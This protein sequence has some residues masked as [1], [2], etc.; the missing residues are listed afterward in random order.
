MNSN[1]EGYI[2]QSPALSMPAGLNFAGYDNCHATP[3][4]F[5][6]GCLGESAFPSVTRLVSEL[7]TNDVPQLQ[8]AGKLQLFIMTTTACLVGHYIKL[9]NNVSGSNQIVSLI[10]S[11]AQRAAI[12]DETVPEKNGV[13]TRWHVVLQE[14]SKKILDDFHSCNPL[15][16]SNN[17]SLSDRVVASQV[18]ALSRRVELL[19]ARI[20]NRHEDRTAVELARD[21]SAIQA[22]QV[23]QLKIDN[24]ML[25]RENHRLKSAL[26][27]LAA[28]SPAKGT[29]GDLRSP[30]P[31]EAAS[32]NLAA[33]FNWPLSGSVHQ[34]DD[35]FVNVLGLQANLKETSVVR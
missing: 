14:W 2:A 22:S 17:S 26:A 13:F 21:S 23:H 3:Q 18:Q 9:V 33:E 12:N 24:E 5:S 6:F 20:Q 7:F 4:A 30:L 1:A 32:C 29:A 25:K 27:S 35:S 19:G 8:E 11:A 10:Q 31:T 28:Q 15:E 34:Q 16:A